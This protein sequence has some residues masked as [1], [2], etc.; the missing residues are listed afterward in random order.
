MVRCGSLGCDS[1]WVHLAQVSSVP[2]GYGK[3]WYAF[4]AIIFQIP[5]LR[6]A[7]AGRVRLSSVR[8]RSD[9]LGFGELR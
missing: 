6:W 1:T 8:V 7:K 5:K 2:L 3:V 9:R 4:I